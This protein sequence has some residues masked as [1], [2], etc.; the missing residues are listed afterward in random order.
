MVFS[1]PSWWHRRRILSEVTRS[2][3]AV[4]NHRVTNPYHA[5]SIEAGRGC[6]QTAQLFGDRRFLSAEAPSLPTPACSPTDCECHYVHHDDRRSESD[7]RQRDVW[8]P[9]MRL[10]V[11]GERR[12][13]AGRR[14]TDH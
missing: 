12:R 13:H 1:L 4:Q 9:H 5:V 10:A 14:A 6:P 2:G 8:N 7:R 3:R 11:G